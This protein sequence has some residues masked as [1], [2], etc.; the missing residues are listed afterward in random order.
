MSSP[1]TFGQVLD[2]IES[3]PADEQTELLA[4]MRRRLSERGR[5]RVIEEAEEA[6]REFADGKCSV[7]T[8][9][10]IMRELRQ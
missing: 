7:A 10:E 9:D 4:I 6:S 1:V 5:E 3:L 8:V 2:A